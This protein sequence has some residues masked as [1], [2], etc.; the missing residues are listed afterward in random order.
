[1][2][3]RWKSLMCSFACLSLFAV[4]D[5]ERESGHQVLEGFHDFGALALLKVLEAAGDDHHAHQHDAQVE[6][7][8]K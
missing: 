6:L 7:K 2:N 4:P 5:D 3:A 8:K 1:M